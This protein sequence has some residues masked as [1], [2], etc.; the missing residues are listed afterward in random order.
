M[1]EKLDFLKNLLKNNKIKFL[2]DIS[3]KKLS[4]N[5]YKNINKIKFDE[6]WLLAANSDIKKGILDPN[7][8][9]NNTYLTTFNFL[10]NIENYLK[11]NL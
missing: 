8:D 10:N 9:F 3:K 6:V 5:F 2:N 4:K 1:V 7:L 11:K